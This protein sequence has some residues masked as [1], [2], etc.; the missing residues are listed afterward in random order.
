ACSIV[1]KFL[2]QVVDR[3]KDGVD[4]GNLSSVL[5]ELGDRLYNTILTHT[6]FFSYNTTG[7]MLLLCDINEYKKC[8]NGWGVKETFKKFDA[9]HALAN[10]LVVVPDNLPKACSSQLLASVDK[11]LVN[12]FVQLRHDYK[13]AKLYQTNY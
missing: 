9:L 3:I 10:L 5:N 13:S 1:V 6:R 11:Q 12:S 7:A 8:V 4:G 2:N